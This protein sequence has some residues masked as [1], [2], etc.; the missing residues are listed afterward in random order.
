MIHAKFRIVTFGSII[1][2]GSIKLKTFRAYNK[3]TIQEFILLL[4]A[5]IK[6][7]RKE[8]GARRSCDDILLK[9]DPKFPNKT[10]T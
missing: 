9:F 6:R 10:I 7:Q 8:A 4:I 2:Q 5:E 1:P 3:K